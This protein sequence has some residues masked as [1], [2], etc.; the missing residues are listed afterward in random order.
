MSE[1][2]RMYAIDA[3][4]G[5]ALIGMVLMHLLPTTN[6]SNT[7]LTTL[8]YVFSGTS[9]ALFMFCAGLSLNFIKSNRA[10]AIR[11]VLLILLGLTLASFQITTAMI[12]VNYGI[13]FLLL[14]PFRKLKS[15][16]LIVITLFFLIGGPLIS[17]H[18]RHGL[19][20]EVQNKMPSP[21]A[22]TTLHF[23]WQNLIDL[24]FT[25]YY[26]LITFSCYTLTGIL[27]ARLAL[28]NSSIQYWL[29]GT[30]IAMFVV[31]YFTSWHSPL[32]SLHGQAPLQS[33]RWLNTMAPHAGTTPE[34]IHNLGYCFFFIAFFLFIEARYPATLT[35]LVALGQI[36]LSL[37]TIHCLLTIVTQEIWIHAIV[38]GIV[39]LYCWHF[40]KS[41]PLESLIH[42][43]VG[44]SHSTHKSYDKSADVR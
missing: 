19:A 23:G 31:P 14:I 29:M 10:L 26:P 22:F 30:G 17:W 12:L 38:L 15:I 18:F 2:K 39:T 25:G 11:S 34:M 20:P 35:P 40:K 21:P 32:A 9:V 13:L 43:S 37:Y 7:E 27:I 16:Y 44:L 28:R 42:A 6:E 4:R 1:N 36:T 33:I 3:A 5:L 8:G 41:G 24:F